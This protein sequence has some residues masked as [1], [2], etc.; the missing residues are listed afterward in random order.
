MNIEDFKNFLIEKKLNDGRI[1]KF[2]KIIEKY[3]KSYELSPNKEDVLSFS[4]D[5]IEEGLN[6]NDSYYALMTYGKFAEIDTLYVTALELIDGTEAM[7]NLYNKIAEEEGEQVR[8]KIFEGIQVP[9]LGTPLYKLPAITQ[10]V[11]GKMEKEL[12]EERTKEMLCNCLRDLDDNWFTEKKKKYEE[13]ENLDDYLKI[14][15]DDFIA[16]LT[17]IMNE[18]DHFFTQPINQD[19]IDHVNANPQVRQGVRK[20]NI[21]YETKI[22]FMSIEYLAETDEDLKRYYFC[23]CP[24][25]RESLVQDDVKVSSTF[26]SCSSGFHKREW[27]VVLGQPLKAE[28]VE[29]VL[30]GD[31]QCSFAIHLPDENK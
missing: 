9:P 2:I 17:R 12:G 10:H 18:N 13:A 8:E 4:E 23:H 3:N 25:V 16:E 27:E 26:C 29:S 6:E 30:D 19:V 28:V 7:G 15:G 24:W 11:M 20:G 5:L 14:K 1:E 21:I 31:L 22:P